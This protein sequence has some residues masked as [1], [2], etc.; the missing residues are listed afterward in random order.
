MEMESDVRYATPRGA[1]TN[2][3]GRS[4][5]EGLCRERN[6][7]LFQGSR[8]EVFH[9]YLGSLPNPRTKVPDESIFEKK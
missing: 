7:I 8:R 2:P 1:E 9:G 6:I 3:Y 4:S 5:G